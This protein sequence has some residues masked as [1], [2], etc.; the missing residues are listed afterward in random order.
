[1]NRILFTLLALLAIAT[2]RADD[3]KIYLGGNPLQEGSCGDMR[4]W[5]H[6]EITDGDASYIPATKQLVLNSATI[7]VELMTALMIYEPITILLKGT[8]TIICKSTDAILANADITITSF[9]AEHPGTLICQSIDDA[10]IPTTGAGICMSGNATLTIKDCT[11]EATGAYGLKHEGEG[12]TLVFNNS[13]VSAQGFNASIFD[14]Q[15]TTASDMLVGSAFYQPAGAE[16]SN[17]SVCVGG[18]VTTDEVT[19]MPLV[20]KDEEV[21]S[22]HFDGTNQYATFEKFNH[23]GGETHLTMS[24]FVSYDGKK[25]PV[26]SIAAGAFSGAS[27]LTLINIASGVTYIGANAFEGCTKLTNVTV[28]S[29][30]P[31]T[32]EPTS[33][34]NAANITLKLPIGSSAAY[35]AAP[36][37]SEFKAFDN[38]LPVTLDNGFSFVK[39]TEY[40]YCL[41]GYFG[42]ATDITIPETVT[43]NGFTFDVSGIESIIDVDGD[44]PNTTLKS[45]TIPASIKYISQYGL[46]GCIALTSITVA[47]DNPVYDSRGG[48]NAVIETATN[49]LISGC[50]TTVIP[51]DVKAIGGMAF[52]YAGFSS[53]TIP[54]GVT[55]IGYA[56][57]GMCSNLTSI[58]LPEGVTKID[59]ATFIGCVSLTSFTI[60][61]TVTT[62]VDGAFMNCSG[63]TSIVI[64]AT[65]SKVGYDAFSGCTSLTSVVFEDAP[66][67]ANGVFDNCTS[68]TDIYCINGIP[69]IKSGTFE[70]K[71]LNNVVLHVPDNLIDTYKADANWSKFKTIV[72]LPQCATPTI[73]VLPGGKLHFDCETEGVTFH[74]SITSVETEGQDVYPSE[75][76]T[77]SVYATKTGCAKSPVATKTIEIK[78][79]DVNGDGAIDALDASFIQQY[80][81][82]KMSW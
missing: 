49:T 66:S 54:S 15:N 6:P 68:L 23:T 50:T 53:I 34:P 8:N 79:G 42:T 28:Y 80:V 19:I 81:A 24:E 82:G 56:A 45:I 51:D 62:I 76:Y 32:I 58:T 60:P 17:N 71:V 10:G 25:Y 7:D 57:F 29:S 77:V 21:F 39:D 14:F 5:T 41:N 74:S 63:L 67:M 59:E 11:L 44:T 1:M 31:F 37:W 75:T 20:V 70:T 35:S 4:P 52:S 73:S 22:L 18:T 36:Y 72:E 30:E 64:P 47:A 65:V 78:R 27:A 3:I 38:A 2:S 26:T 61:S 43:V 55:K 33:F 46:V 13:T 9:D 12:G 48:C 40:G 69:T 16:W